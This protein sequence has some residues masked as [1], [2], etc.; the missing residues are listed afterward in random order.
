MR[1]IGGMFKSRLISMPKGTDI[2]PTQDR[3]RESVFN[4]LGDLT[5]ARVLELFA[6]SGAFGIEAISRGAD[7]CTFVENNS[8]CTAAIAANLES[9]QV[10]EYQYDILKANAISVFSRLERSVAGTGERFNL[11]I[12][13]PPYHKDIARKCLINIDTYDILTQSAVIV[14][15]HFRKDNLVFDYKNIVPEKERRYG[16]TLISIFRKRHESKDRDLPRNI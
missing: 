9:L 1:I 3:V 10:P 12:L 5:G 6:G 4:L 14:V 8:K 7:H 2:R 13:D 11:V 15:E 16:D